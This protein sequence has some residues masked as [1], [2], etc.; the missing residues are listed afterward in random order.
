MKIRERNFEDKVRKE[1]HRR[2]RDLE[3]EALAQHNA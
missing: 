2:Q 3:E 1:E